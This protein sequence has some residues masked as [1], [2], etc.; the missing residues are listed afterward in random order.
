MGWLA[1]TIGGTAGLTLG[2]PLGAIC[3]KSLMELYD[4]NTIPQSKLNLL[5]TQN[6]GESLTAA[7]KSRLIFFL[8]LISMLGKI[9]EAE[10]K[11]TQD[12]LDTTSQIM[13]GPLKLTGLALTLGKMVFAQARREKVS[14]KA[15]AEQFSAE[16]RPKSQRVNQFMIEALLVVAFAD[17]HFDPREWRMIA[18]VAKVIGVDRASLVRAAEKHTSKGDRNWATLRLDP[19][20]PQGQ[21]KKK[22]AALSALFDPAQLEKRGIPAEM[23]KFAGG[24]QKAVQKSAAAVTRQLGK[25]ARK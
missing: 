2:G 11:V 8:A 15:I 16:F 18:M 1:K 23:E 3:G 24:Q 17:G 20:A 9:V 7:E 6:F 22:E 13:L 10:N 4:S 14:C 19:F 21:V 12:E 5:E 25:Q